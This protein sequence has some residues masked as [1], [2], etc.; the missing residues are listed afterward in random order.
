V[1]PKI[2]AVRKPGRHGEEHGRDIWLEVDGGVKADNARRVGEAG[3]DTWWPARPSSPAAR[4]T[5]AY[6]EAIAGIRD[7]A[8]AGQQRLALETV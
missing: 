8:L 1:L 4:N 2:E 5:A 6:A 7:E 3:A